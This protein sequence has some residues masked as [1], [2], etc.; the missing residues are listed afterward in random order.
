MY[1]SIF[2]DGE[3]A[4]HNLAPGRIACVHV[5]RGRVRANG[6][7]LE[8]GDALKLVDED[9]VTFNGLQEAEWLLF[10]LPARRE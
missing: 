1:A 3:Q 6:Q 10:D 5:A 7:T 4:R 8:S 9:G 2:G